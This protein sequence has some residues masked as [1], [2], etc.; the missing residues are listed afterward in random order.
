MI[1]D[2]YY[3]LFVG[4]GLVT[5]YEDWAQ[6]RVRNRWIALGL[7]AGAAGLTYLLWNSVLGHQGVRLGRFGEYYLPWRYY[8]KVFIHMGLSLTAAFTMWRLA[9][10]PAGDAKL[11]ILF[12][13]L[14]VLIDP[15]I[16]GYPLL[17]FM[18]LLVNIF[19]PA[20]LLFA[21]ETVARVLLRAGELWGV[22]WGVW[23]KAKLDVVGVRLREAWPHRY[24]YLA[25]AVNLFALFYLSGTAQ[26]YSHRLHWGAFGNVILF[27]LMFVA[28]GKI[29]Q[30]LQDRRAGYASVAVLAAA[31]AWGSHW[32][33]WDVPAIALS[34]LQMAFN[35][36][37]LVSFARLLFHWHI[38]RESRRRLSA[39]NIEPGVVL[40]D[41]TWQTLAAEPELAEALG[42]RLSDGLSVEEAA[43]VKAWLEGRRSETDYAFYRTIPFAV[44]IFL[45]SFYT[46]TQRNNLVTALIP[47]LGKWW[48]AFMAVGGG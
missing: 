23:L 33:G 34:A 5:S 14:A 2:F 12:S 16:P 1:A 8:L 40:S 47:W 27:L 11:F 44:W 36:G 20:G 32:R 19:V 39:E 43:A 28:W 13:L 3:Y 38:E 35:F 48:D 18:L 25:M 15:N 29:S 30:V 41:D 37:V 6:R 10:W 42:R 7:L 26:R 24:Q 17:L 46:V 21:A 45:G 9:I 31:M 4:L 22:D